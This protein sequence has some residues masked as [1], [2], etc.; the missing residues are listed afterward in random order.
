MT[1]CEGL[2]AL[3]ALGEEFPEFPYCVGLPKMN[4]RRARKDVFTIFF[5]F[6]IQVLRPL[7]RAARRTDVG[8]NHACMFVAGATGKGPLIGKEASSA[9][10]FSALPECLCTTQESMSFVVVPRNASMWQGIKSDER[11]PRGLFSTVWRQSIRF[12]DSFREFP[13]RDLI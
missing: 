13:E 10:I 2:I 1:S 7:S 8:I 4:S 6:S 11:K 3:K 5:I 12:M 9:S